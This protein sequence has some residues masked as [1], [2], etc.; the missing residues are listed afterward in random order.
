MRSCDK[1]GHLLYVSQVFMSFFI[2]ILEVYQYSGGLS[3]F[4]PVTRDQK[5]FSYF[6]WG[7]SYSNDHKSSGGDN[8][9]CTPFGLNVAAPTCASGLP[10]SDSLSY[11]AKETR[12]H[13]NGLQAT[14]SPVSKLVTVPS[15]SRLPRV[16]FG[17][18]LEVFLTWV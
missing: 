2:N 18:G 17:V 4:W 7:P 16:G 12:L 10:V 1:V 9:I 15:V 6:F 13:S 5:F 3:I 11:H 8:W 14:G